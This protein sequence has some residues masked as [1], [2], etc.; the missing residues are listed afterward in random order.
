MELISENLGTD[1]TIKVVIE[2]GKLGL[3]LA[4]DTKGLDGNVGLFVDSDYFLDELAKVLPGDFDNAIIAV[5][6]T[7]LKSL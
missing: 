4:L 6:K 1:A 2:K 3:A 5:V 7:A